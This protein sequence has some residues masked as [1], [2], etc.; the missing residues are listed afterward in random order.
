MCKWNIFKKDAGHFFIDWFN[1]LW[2]KDTWLKDLKKKSF[3][4]A[5]FKMF[6]ASKCN[7]Y[8]GAIPF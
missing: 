4:T 3:H 6:L 7:S 1:V 5:L 8:R 2:G